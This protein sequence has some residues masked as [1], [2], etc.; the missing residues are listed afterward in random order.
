MNVHAPTEN[1]IVDLKDRFYEELEHVFDK[2][3]KYPMKILLTDFNAKVWREDIFKP[4]MG[5][6]WH[7]EQLLDQW[8]GSIIVPVHKK[9]DKTDCSNYRGISLLSTSYKNLS[10]IL[11]SRLSPYVDEIIGDHQCGFRRNKS[12]TEQIFCIRQ[13]LE[14]KWEYDETVHQ[15]FVD[16][17]K[18]YNSDRREVLYNILIEFGIPIK[19][20]R[21]IKMCLNERYS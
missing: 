5:F 14:K 18:A 19:L 13:I 11:L 2:F 21:L 7:K 9:G 1:K 3:P 15:L 6:F 17:K 8:K 16:F 4:I 12:T 20:V 10:N